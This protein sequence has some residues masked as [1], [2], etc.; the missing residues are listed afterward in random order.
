MLVTIS[1]AAKMVNVSRATIY[2]DIESG[3]L[4]VEVGAKGRKMVDISELTRVYKTLKVPDDSDISKTVKK[5]E[6]RQPTDVSTQSDKVAVL[7]ERIEAQR[8]QAELL[9]EMLKR[10]KEERERE[11]ESAK[12]FEEYFKTQIETQAESIKNFTR[13][14]E[15]QRVDKPD[16]SDV[17][18]KSL[19]ALEDRIANQEA[20]IQEKVALEAKE[21]EELK[22]QLEEKEKILAEKEEALKIEKSK[23]F[24]HKLFGR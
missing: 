16:T 15:D 24:V 8:K 12:E 22:A 17:W 2:N 9:E 13:L 20:A 6:K 3:T 10:E 23:S 14:L 4:S 18:Q 1:E 19:K 7:Q 21:K 5:E 11:R